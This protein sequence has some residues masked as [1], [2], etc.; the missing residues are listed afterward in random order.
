M[1]LLARMCTLIMHEGGQQQQ[2]QHL[3][4]PKENKIKVIQEEEESLEDAGEGTPVH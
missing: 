4:I 3:F 2:Q 1:G